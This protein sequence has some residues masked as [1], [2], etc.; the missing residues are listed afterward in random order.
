MCHDV[1]NM[2]QQNVLYRYA[3]RRK[4]ATTE[5]ASSQSGVLSSEQVILGA[6]KKPSILLM[7]T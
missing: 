2:Y 4:G 7:E 3:G 6:A 1:M 5:W